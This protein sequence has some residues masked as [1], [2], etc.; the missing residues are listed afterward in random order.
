MWDEL[1]SG[2][3]GPAACADR[4][5]AAVERDGPGAVPVAEQATVVSG[6]ATHVGAFDVDG[7]GPDALVSGFDGFGDME[8]LVGDGVVGDPGVDEGHAHRPVAQQRGDRLEAP[9]PVDRLG[10][11]GVAKLVVMD[12]TDPGAPPPNLDPFST[13]LDEKRLG[14][15]VW[16]LIDSETTARSCRRS[17]SSHG[18]RSAR[19]FTPRSIWGDIT[20]SVGN[21]AAR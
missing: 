9:A 20:K 17:G 8:L 1:G 21:I 10:G 7:D 13:A 6:E 5:E 3:E 16:L 12:V 2:V 15:Y 14:Y 19:A 11:Q 18:V 4:I